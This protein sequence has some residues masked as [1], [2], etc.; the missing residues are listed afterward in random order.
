MI[1][2]KNNVFPRIKNILFLKGRSGKR[3]TNRSGASFVGK[4]L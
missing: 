2:T 1:Q 3:Q 4:G